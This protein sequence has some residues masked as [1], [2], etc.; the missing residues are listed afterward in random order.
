MTMY[1]PGLDE[2]LFQIISV[3]RWSVFIDSR[4]RKVLSKL[5]VKLGFAANKFVIFKYS[6]IRGPPIK[7]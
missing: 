1:N 7:A 5:N 6:D 4:I 3:G 2:P